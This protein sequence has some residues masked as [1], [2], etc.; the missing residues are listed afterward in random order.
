MGVFEIPLNFEDLVD[1]TDMENHVKIFNSIDIFRDYGQDR[2][3]L[4]LII[5]ETKPVFKLCLI[6][7]LLDGITL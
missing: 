7:S 6:F 4:H 3:Y 1:D 2:H 5:R